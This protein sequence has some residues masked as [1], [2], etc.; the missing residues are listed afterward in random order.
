MSE[1]TGVDLAIVAAAIQKARRMIDAEFEQV[2]ETID[3]SPTTIL[4]VLAKLDRALQE[5]SKEIQ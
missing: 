4:F 2:G 1:A 5:I 3:Y